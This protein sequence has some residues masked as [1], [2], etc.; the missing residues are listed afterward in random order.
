MNNVSLSESEWLRTMAQRQRKAGELLSKSTEEQRGLGYFHTLREI[1]QQ[2][3]S[4]MQT[5]ELL[6]HASSALHNS[7]K[8]IRSLILT[9][10][11]SSEYAGDCVRLPLQNELKIVTQALG[12]GA[13]LAHGS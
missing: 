7:I 1:C 11:G 10:S 3:A 6:Q 2:P 5:C 4:W 12:G 9:G 13:I 8:G